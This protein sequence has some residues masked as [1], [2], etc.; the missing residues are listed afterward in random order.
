MFLQLL[1]RSFPKDHVFNKTFNRHTVKISYST[2]PNVKKRID[3]HNS[4]IMNKKTA[5]KDEKTCNCK[6]PK[7]NPQ[8][9]QCPI[10]PLD[11]EGR[12]HCLV[13][14]VVYQAD[15]HTVD[16]KGKNLQDKDGK[17]LPPKI[18]YG[19]TER[20]FKDRLTEHKQAFKNRKSVLSTLIIKLNKQKY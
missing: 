19:L 17:E 18:Y 5:N 7:V 14:S 8:K 2:M 15:V 10:G 16:E 1:D 20:S 11:K 4:K 6:I 3:K 13:K 12:G 9:K